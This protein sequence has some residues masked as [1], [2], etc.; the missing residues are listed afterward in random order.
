MLAMSRCLLLFATL[1]GAAVGC[2][3][4]NQSS[5][6]Q[7]LLDSE[8]APGLTCHAQ[9]WCVTTPAEERDLVLRMAP[10][11]GSG[12]VLEYFDGT[13]GGSAATLGQAWQ[14][15]E[16]AVVRGTVQRA[17]DALAASI[18]GRLLATAPSKVLGASLRYEA[19]SLN[20]LKFFDGATTPAGFELR[21]QIGPSY[22]V[23]FW[24]DSTTIPPYYSSWTVSGSA[25]GWAVVLPA[26]ASLIRVRGR[27]RQGSAAS[28]SCAAGA[29]GGPSCAD[30]CSGLPGVA[31]Q[32]EDAAGRIRSSRVVTDADGAFEL[33]VDPNAG[34]VRLVLQP[35]AGSGTGPRGRLAQAI[36]L[37]LLRKQDKK[38]HDLGDL[39]VYDAAQL[40][41]RPVYVVDG[42]GAAVA[43]AQVS[44]RVELQ[45]VLRCNPGND[46]AKLVPL[47]ENL[48]VEWSGL[49]GAD[50]SVAPSLPPGKA[51]VRVVPPMQH[52]VGAT[53]AQFDAAAQADWTVPCPDRRLFVG[54]L[55][56][57]TQTPIEQARVRLERLASETAGDDTSSAIAWVETDAAGAFAVRADPGRYAVVVEPPE[58]SGLARA[59]L[60]VI[61]VAPEHDPVPQTLVLPAPSVLS[62]R[63]LD[64]EGNPAAQVLVDVFAQQVSSLVALGGGPGGGQGARQP[65]MSDGEAALLTFETHRLGSTTTGLDGRFEVLIVASQL[66][67][68]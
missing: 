59:V 62:G 29:V 32:L 15:T 7:C 50:G 20:T 45:S 36:D 35:G 24:P 23:V 65:G 47:F 1:L 48:R 61:E 57:I 14:L 66:V 16:P 30:G 26:E 49:T 67:A 17:G 13:I 55:V 21:M 19:Q 39:V 51:K 43:G 5:P 44:V 6:G 37:D 64:A 22:D 42:A 31:V 25:D 52:D 56:D 33:R 3:D 12:A 38:Q 34:P 63:V 58:G 60:K 4:L 40:S 9:R 53:V 11:P 46:D 28:L 8:C 2:G 68:P 54:T 10:V 41:A 27:L 18:P